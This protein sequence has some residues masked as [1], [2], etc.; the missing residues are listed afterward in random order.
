MSGLGSVF[1]LGACG[2]LVLVGICRLRCIGSILL[3]FPAISVDTCENSPIESTHHKPAVQ[4][5]AA[6]I[7]QN[8]VAST[9]F[10]PNHFLHLSNSG[11]IRSVAGIP[12]GSLKGVCLCQFKS[13][14]IART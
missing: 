9:G 8:V 7:Y 13:V 3:D 1:G 11:D 14:N 12:G 10:G 5:A 2:F 6:H 4:R